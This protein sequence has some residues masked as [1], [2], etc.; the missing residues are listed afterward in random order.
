M[1]TFLATLVMVVMLSGCGG[2]SLVSTP[3]AFVEA[4]WKEEVQ[5][6]R[7]QLIVVDRATVPG[8]RFYSMDGSS[9]FFEP[10]QT[11]RLPDGTIWNR[12]DIF[13]PGTVATVGWTTSRA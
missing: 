2:Y 12:K 5:L 13:L 3:I 4:K 7:G 9:Y 1:Q 8:A 10:E 11:L 6:G